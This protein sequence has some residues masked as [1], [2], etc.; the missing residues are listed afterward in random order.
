M[1]RFEDLA[2]F[3]TADPV[4]RAV[5]E[6]AAT[7]LQSSSVV[8]GLDALRVA[9]VDFERAPVATRDAYFTSNCMAVVPEHG[10]VVNENFLRDAEIAIRAFGL[11]GSVFATPFL[12]H[13]S[14]MFAFVRRV[15]AHPLEYLAALRTLSTRKEGEQCRRDELALALVFFLGHEVEHLRDRGDRRPFTITLPEG[16]ALETQ[17][18]AA[19]AKYCRHVDELHSFGFD[20]PG[21]D[22]AFTR[23][24]EVRAAADA[25]L[26]TLP[27]NQAV[28][29]D[30][31]FQAEN[32]ADDCGIEVLVQVLN[33]A[34]LWNE[35]AVLAPFL[36]VRALFAVGVVSWFR[37]FLGLLEQLS[38]EP[39]RA[40]VGSLIIDMMSDRQNYVRASSVFGHEHRFTLLRAAVA[41]GRVLKQCAIE[42][43]DE[44]LR[45]EVTQRWYLCRLL[46]DTAVKLAST[47]A[48]TA[49]MLQKDKERGTPQLFMMQFESLAGELN[50]LRGMGA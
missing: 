41:M 49:W 37:D 27:P 13:E 7:L 22:L 9:I 38:P 2:A 23:G 15:R 33:A 3:E 47:G 32:R 29:H 39:E 12:R 34:G 8:Q 14:E 42:P 43:S 36:A 17:L 28:N 31:W 50:R 1:N 11:S 18:A 25:V 35:T 46:M 21:F 44:R 30:A 5:G 16:A 45:A 6:R 48:S 24:S 40:N 4:L 10:I 20:L 26:A 19:T